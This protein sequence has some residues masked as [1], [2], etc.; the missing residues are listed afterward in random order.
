M[1]SFAA[2]REATGLTQGELADLLGLT[3][4]AISA[5]EAGRRTPTGPAVPWL[6]AVADALE[7]PHRVYRHHRGRAVELPTVRWRP[8]VPTDATVVLPTRLDWSPRVSRSRDLSDDDDRASTYAQVLEE[9]SASDI[10]IWV[11]PDALRRLWPDLPIARHM[12]EPV[13]EMLASIEA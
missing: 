9:G 8:A 3:Q 11:D 2:A 1:I 4:P 5:Y 13:T 7:V 6:E 10:A 12:V